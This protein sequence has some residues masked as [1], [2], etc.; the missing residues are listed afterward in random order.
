MNDLLEV[1]KGCRQLPETEIHSAK[2]GAPV[3]RDDLCKRKTYG[4]W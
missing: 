1:I 3:E 2:L 4:A